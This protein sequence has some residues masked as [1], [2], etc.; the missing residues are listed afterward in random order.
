VRERGRGD[1]GMTTTQV[2][3]LFPAVLFWLMLIV[4][5]G[6]WWHAKQVANAAAAEAVDAAQVQAGTAAEG[7]SA[8]ASFLA[9]SG[10]LADVTITVDRGPA[11]VAAEIR[12]N[13]PRLVPGFA[14]TVTARSQAPVE[15]FIP[16]PE[17]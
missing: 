8:A 11:I 17:R 15:R 2:A 6:L 4:Q 3:V 1:A 13:A 16:E 9:Q 7:E 10:N 14:W 12:G 5:Y